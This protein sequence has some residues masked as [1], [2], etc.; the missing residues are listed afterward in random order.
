MTRRRKGRADV[1][2]PAISRTAYR[3]ARVRSL[4]DAVVAR[5]GDAGYAAFSRQLERLDADQRQRL[6]RES[7]DVTV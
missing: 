2:S 5:Y 4:A 6:G 1:Y 7:S 3:E